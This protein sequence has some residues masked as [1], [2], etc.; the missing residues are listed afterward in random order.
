MRFRSSNFYDK[1]IYET[2][3]FAVLPSLGGFVEGWTLI[4]PKAPTINLQALPQALHGEFRELTQ[5]VQNAVER[6]YG[7]ASLFEH[8]PE[9]AGSL[10]GCGADQAHLHVVPFIFA[11]LPSV[12]G[13]WMAADGAMPFD[14]PKALG[15]YLW[16]AS[17]GLAHICLPA[18][19]T[20]QF[21]RKKIAESLGASTSWDYKLQPH[22]DTVLA[23]SERLSAALNA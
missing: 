6:S 13:E 8:G 2:A 16:L 3:N 5:L 11:D 22:H 10:M 18:V 1:P 17:S 23:T 20:S 15:D 14:A 7:K 4:V 19:V 9:V 21:F 12:D